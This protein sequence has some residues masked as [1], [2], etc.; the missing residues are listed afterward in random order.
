MKREFI[1]LNL[2]WVA[3]TVSAQKEITLYSPDK[4]ITVQIQNT[5]GKLYYSV[6]K[7]GHMILQPSQLGVDFISEVFSRDIS[8]TKVS[9]PVAVQETYSTKNAKKHLIHYM[10]RKTVITVKNSNGLR[11]DLIFQL[12]NDGL[13][14]HYYFP[15][16]QAKEVI[17]REHTSFVFDTTARAWLQPMSVAKSGWES[18]NPAYEEPYYQDVAVGTTSHLKSGWVYPALFHTNN[19]WMLIT[20]AGLDGS[21]CGTRLMNNS[22]SVVYTVAFPDTKEVFTGGGHL[23][24]NDKPWF[25]PWRI[26]TIGSLQTLATST[27]GMDVAPKEN[28]M[29]WSFAKPGKAS[30]SWISSKDD[31]IVYAEQKK[32]ID[33]AA[34][35]KWRYCLI[36]VNWDTKI[37]YEKIKELADYGKQKNVGLIL[38]YNSAGDWNT[39]KYHPKDLLLTTESRHREFSRLRAMGIKGVK[40]DF[41]GGDGQSMIQHYLDIL[42]DAATFHLLVNFHGATLPRGWQKTYPHLITAEAVYGM[43]M[44][45]FSQAAADAQPRHCTILP[46]TRNA[47]DPMDFTPMNLTG[48]THSGS[49]RKTSPA[50]ELALSVLFLSGIQHYAQNAEAINKIPGYVIH[51]LQT[52]PD[53]WDD[54]KFLEGFPGKYVVLARRSGTNWY[55]A[56]INGENKE[57]NL[58]IDLSSFKKNQCR[59]LTDSGDETFISQTELSNTN[60][61]SVTLKA[62]GG[63]V[64][65]LK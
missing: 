54:V 50:F 40:I 13:A 53:Y 45:T 11:A 47:F 21:Y 25:T 58:E 64:A 22:A 39:V 10:A 52:L 56:G 26:I 33:L 20:E 3:V 65:V 31:Q 59:L 38:W 2:L 51:F 6:K 18:C 19:T 1:L 14:F 27:L 7:D 49:I 60:K 57:R 12:S 28:N 15:W 43:E 42:K 24:V 41:F 36:D 32:Y 30:W 9:G 61:I 34:F 23:P 48:L 37:G 17:V 29:D 5:E 46:F 4:N 62:A 63:F 44:V 8:I 35:L 16:I 55:I